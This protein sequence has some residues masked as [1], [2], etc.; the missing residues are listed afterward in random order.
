MTRA[1]R[2]LGRSGRWLSVGN[3]WRRMIDAKNCIIAPFTSESINNNGLVSSVGR[4]DI[5]L[6]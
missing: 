2:F 6:S 1:F 3:G 5:V 4:C